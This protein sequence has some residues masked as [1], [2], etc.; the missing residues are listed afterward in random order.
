MKKF[1]LSDRNFRKRISKLKGMKYL[2][3][4][5]RDLKLTPEGEQ[6]LD[7]ENETLKEQ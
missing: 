6:R 7:R 2:F 5:G 4:E 1:D 3:E